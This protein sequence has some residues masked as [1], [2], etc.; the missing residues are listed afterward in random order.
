MF[1]YIIKD[2]M[3]FENKFKLFFR[4][5]LYYFHKYVYTI[6]IVYTRG[7][8]YASI[9][10]SKLCDTFKHIRLFT[11]IFPNIY[12]K[13]T[14]KHM[15]AF[16]QIWHYIYTHICMLPFRYIHANPLYI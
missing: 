1:K 13:F 4:H 9:L 2:K 12:N 16:M 6:C 10:F 14:S 8:I 7:Y 15:Q 5:S 11:Q 3:I